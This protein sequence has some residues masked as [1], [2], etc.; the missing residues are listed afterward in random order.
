M[1]E[2]VHSFV[3]PFCRCAAPRIRRGRLNPLLRVD[4]FEQVE[5]AGHVGILRQQF[6]QFAESAGLLFLAFGAVR[7]AVDAVTKGLAAWLLRAGRTTH[8]PGLRQFR[9]LQLTV[10]CFFPFF[11][12]YG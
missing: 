9:I 8:N 6:G 12:G 3:L 11:P 2:P 5:D 10:D 4:F 7:L 1:F